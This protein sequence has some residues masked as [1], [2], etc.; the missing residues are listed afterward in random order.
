MYWN[1]LSLHYI[2]VQEMIWS[3]S[4]WRPTASTNKNPPGGPRVASFISTDACP[5]GLP[6]KR[7]SRLVERCVCVAM[8]WETL[9]AYQTELSIAICHL[10][11]LYCAVH[12]LTSGVLRTQVSSSPVATLQPWSWSYCT[13][14]VGRDRHRNHFTPWA[15]AMRPLASLPLRQLRHGRRGH[16]VLYILNLVA[17]R[18]TG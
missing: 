13:C 17:A 12:P 5:S 15:Q 10:I 1:V 8:N 18:F 7:L 3:R 2:V 16:A 11:S 14:W 9:K 6:F 4:P